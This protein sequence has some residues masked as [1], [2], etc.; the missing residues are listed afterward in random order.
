MMR[1]KK[2]AL[3]F[4]QKAKKS[5]TCTYEAVSLDKAKQLH[6]KLLFIHRISKIIII[7]LSL[8]SSKIILLHYLRIKITKTVAYN[9][10]NINNYTIDNIASQRL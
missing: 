2:L 8:S 6:C 9:E 4:I 10:L 5:L 3:K 7:I 1:A